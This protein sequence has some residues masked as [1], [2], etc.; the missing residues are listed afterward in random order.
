MGDYSRSRYLSKTGKAAT[1]Q[2]VKSGKYRNINK[3]RS[4]NNV[5]LGGEVISIEKLS[6]R[7]EIMNMKARLQEL[8]EERNSAQEAI[9]REIPPTQEELDLFKEFGEKIEEYKKNFPEDVQEKTK[10][11][12]KNSEMVPLAQTIL[13]DDIIDYNLSQLSEELLA[14]VRKGDSMAAYT[15][16]EIKKM[17]TAAGELDEEGNPTERAMGLKR[18]LLDVDGLR[19]FWKSKKAKREMK[20]REVEQLAM[21]QREEERKQ[22]EYEAHVHEL[23]NEL[24]AARSQADQ[25]GFRDKFIDFVDERNNTPWG[26]K[27][28]VLMLTGFGFIYAALPFSQGAL[29]KRAEHRIEKEKSSV[30][31][32]RQRY[33]YYAR[34]REA[35]INQQAAIERQFDAQIKMI[36][37]ETDKR[38]KALLP[39]GVEDLSTLVNMRNALR[40]KA[41]IGELGPEQLEQLSILNNLLSQASSIT[42]DL[43][44]QVDELDMQKNKYLKE[45]ERVVVPIELEMQIAEAQGGSV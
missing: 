19:D 6:A 39:D 18:M 21:E 8:Q 37:K 22:R 12:D 10:G 36:Q 29:R 25:R 15:L 23:T 34:Q 3:G 16:K 32:A 38:T 5:Q 9:G 40:K 26:W 42:E 45:L 17:Y 41:E 27:D 20:N 28:T 24:L 30:Q 1:R 7:K 44:K 35:Y 11:S 4:L 33:Q 2:Y 13:V 14:A 31:E 43:E